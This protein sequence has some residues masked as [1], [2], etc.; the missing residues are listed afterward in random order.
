MTNEARVVMDWAMSER[1]LQTTVVR[2]AKALGW[3]VY[4]TWRSDHSEPGFPDLILI[5]GTRLLAV[6]LKRMGKNPTLH[7]VRWLG[8]FAAVEHVESHLVRPCDLDDLERVL[9]GEDG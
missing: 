4:H 5:R 8:L 6:E 2:M 1:A 9:R 3:T 7:Q